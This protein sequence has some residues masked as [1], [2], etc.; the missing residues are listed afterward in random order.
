MVEETVDKCVKLI[1]IK[2]RGNDTLSLTAVA[3]MDSIETAV[4][5][6]LG[7]R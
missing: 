7:I 2:A 3:A 6:E 1:K 5:D 4:F